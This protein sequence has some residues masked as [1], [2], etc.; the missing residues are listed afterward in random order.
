MI[1]KAI[2]AIIGQY[3]A[4][5]TGERLLSKGK[6]AAKAKNPTEQKV[7]K[8]ERKARDKALR[9]AIKKI[10]RLE[11]SV[12]KAEE[13]LK[14]KNAELSEVDPSDRKRMTDLS[15]EFEAVQKKHDHLV[16]QWEDAIIEKEEIEN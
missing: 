3:E 10:Q 15:Y 12:S 7:S 11:K 5:K 6:S 13:E 8:E 16:H 9:Q 4:S 14:L 2:V 1:N